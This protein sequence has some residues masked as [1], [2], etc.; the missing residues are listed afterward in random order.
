MPLPISLPQASFIAAIVASVV[1][2][3]I[4]LTPPNPATESIPKTGDFLRT[5]GVTSN[6]GAN[7][8]VAPLSILALHACALAY[9]YPARPLPRW[10]LLHGAENGLNRN[11]ITWSPATAV[12]LALLLCVGIPLRLIAYSSLGKN[13]TFALAEPDRLTT[14]GVYRFVQHPSYVG[15]VALFLG[16]AA[17]VYRI[18]GVLSCW[19][20]SRWYPT[21]RRL[22][23]LA[24][25]VGLL[26]LATGVWT[27]V[28]QE[29][30]MLAEEF[31]GE[32]ERWH[33]RTARFVP[34]VF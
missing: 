5:V 24:L 6:H 16:H 7:L 10:I 11:L 29:E 28:V 27:R 9:F 33:A 8:F 21:A 22:G 18:D 32:W 15:L 34:G 20:P 17:L 4:G 26:V 31:G 19:I 23:W 30:R 2:T 12:P 14:T 13:F 25:P 1:G 3:Y